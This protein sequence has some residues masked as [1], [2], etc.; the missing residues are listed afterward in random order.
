MPT[1]VSQSK[2]NE[3]GRLIADACEKGDQVSAIASRA[4]VPRSMVSR[5]KDCSY[6]R[7]PSLGTVEAI[8]RAIGREV[9]F[10]LAEGKRD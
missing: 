8:V 6:L 2:L 4:G 3:L 9:A 7:S 1:I 5:I 10:P